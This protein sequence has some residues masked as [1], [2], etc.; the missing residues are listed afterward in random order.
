MHIVF[1]IT[2]VCDVISHVTIRFTICHCLLVVH[3][4]RASISNHFR[5]I[6]PKLMLM[7]T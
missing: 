7:N 1:S 5:H 2:K 4:N 6:W 3:W